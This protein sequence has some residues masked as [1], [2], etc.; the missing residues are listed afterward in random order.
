MQGLRGLLARRGA[1]PHGVEGQAGELFL[2]PNAKRIGNSDDMMKTGNGLKSE[3][4]LGPVP[5]GL[6]A[7]GSNR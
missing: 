3:I 2:I 7:A 5:A 4:A 1:G 6:T